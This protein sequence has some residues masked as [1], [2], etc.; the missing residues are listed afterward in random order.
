[1]THL[2]AAAPV[3]WLRQVLSPEDVRRI[4]THF[5]E[6]LFK[7][8]GA[9]ERLVG[10]PNS[11]AKL[12]KQ[13]PLVRG[14]DEAEFGDIMLNPLVGALKMGT[15]LENDDIVRTNAKPMLQLV[16][17]MPWNFL[18]P[19]DEQFREPSTI[20]FRKWHPPELSDS[21]FVT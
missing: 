3:R 15:S 1:M 17:N 8:W 6:Q 2:S 7:R 4:A 13:S 16:A 5:V 11:V 12:T 18:A 21:M 20:K 9:R 14:S 19:S 10:A